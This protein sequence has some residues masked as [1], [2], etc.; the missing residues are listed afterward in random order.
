ME[1]YQTP[2]VSVTL[3]EDGRVAGTLT[4]GKLRTDGAAPVDGRSNVAT[5]TFDVVVNS[6]VLDGTVI[7]N[8]GFVS[9]V[10]GGV[11]D[12]PSDDPDTPT[13]DD[14]TRDVVG[15]LPLLYAEKSAALSDR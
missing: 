11:T 8:Q 13:A 7:S 2:G 6:D 12:Q 1:R 3:V 15:N 4:R 14:P 5:I 10:S 9:A